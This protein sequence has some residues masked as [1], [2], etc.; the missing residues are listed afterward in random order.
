MTCKW[1]NFKIGRTTE[2][3]IPPG[4]ENACD[5]CKAITISGPKTIYGDY[6]GIVFDTEMKIVLHKVRL[7]NPILCPNCQNIGT[8]WYHACDD[9]SQ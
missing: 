9:A 4:T 6:M 5:D 2:I 3:N 1:C 8:H 7:D